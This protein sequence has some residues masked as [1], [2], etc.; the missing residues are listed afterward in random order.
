MS[1]HIIGNINRKIVPSLWF[2][3]RASQGFKIVMTIPGGG[4]TTM[5]GLHDSFMDGP[6]VFVTSKQH[7]KM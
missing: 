7:K 2:F 1:R 4:L 3:A 5:D 6:M